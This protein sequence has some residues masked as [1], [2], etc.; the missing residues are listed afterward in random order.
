MSDS[1]YGTG[2]SSAPVSAAD[3]HRGTAST[4]TPVELA[5]QTAVPVVEADHEPAAVGDHLGRSAPSQ[6]I[7]WA[8]KPITSR[9]AGSSG[10]PNVSYSSSIPDGSVARAHGTSVTRDVARR[11]TAATGRAA[12]SAAEQPSFLLV[13]LAPCESVP[14]SNRPSS[15]SSCDATS[16]PPRPARESPRL[17]DLHLRVDQVLHPLGTA[18]VG[19]ALLTGLAA[20]LDQQVAG[21]EH[22]LEDRSG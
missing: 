5:R 11:G 18:D 10:D 19:E 14:R 13:E 15:F 9:S 3:H 22:A 17:V 16:L 2:G 8:V 21:S 6:A 4:A 20:R 7:I 1:V 12:R